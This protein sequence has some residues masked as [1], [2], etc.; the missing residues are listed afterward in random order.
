[1]RAEDLKLLLAW[2][3]A[4]AKAQRDG[5]GGLEGAG[6]A[7]RTLVRLIRKVWD[8]EEIPG[9]DVDHNCGLNPKGKLRGLPRDRIA[10]GG[11]EGD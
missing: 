7:W 11:V 2:A 5:D 10:G 6:N 4:K 3:E 9:K 8:M 1:M